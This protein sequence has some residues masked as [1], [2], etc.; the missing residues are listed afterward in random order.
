MQIVLNSS[1]H[2][3]RTTEHAPPDP[4]RVLERRHGLAKIVERAAGVL[5]ER[6]RIRDSEIGPTGYEA[7]PRSS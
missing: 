2:R 3:V 5:D 4:R 7:L 1:C 6:L